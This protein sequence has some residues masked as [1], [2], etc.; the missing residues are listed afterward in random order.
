MARSVVLSVLSEDRVGIIANVTRAILGMKGNIGAISETVM[1]GHFTIILTVEFDDDMALDAIKENVEK[2]G[3]PGELHA[4]VLSTDSQEANASA[5]PKGDQF[6]ITI[7]GKDQPGIIN[8]ITAY[9]ASRNINIVDL[10]A[11]AE[12]DQFIVI[13]QVILPP[14]QD[15]AQVQ[16]DLETL[17]PDGSI[18]ARLQHSNIFAATNEV[19]FHHAKRRRH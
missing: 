16:I 15:S 12:E 2:I 5:A 4:S 19:D 9:L 3:Q 8:R 1:E 18:E 11:Y 6:V 10:S 17:W 14:E 13:G 7:L